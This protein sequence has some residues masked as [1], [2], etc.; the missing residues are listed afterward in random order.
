LVGADPDIFCPKNVKR[1]K[2][3]TFM[4]SN[5]TGI[6][7]NDGYQT[8]REL[9]EA[10]LKRGLDLHIYG[11]NWEYLA[12]EPNLHIH[13]FVD[14]EQ[15]AKA[16]SRSRITIGISGTSNVRKANSWR[17][18]FNSMACGAFHLTLYVPGMEEIFENRKH[19]VW[20]NSVPEAIELIEYYLAHD[21]EREQIAEAGR[22][23]ILAHH[24][25]DVRIAEMIDIYER[26]RAAVL[27]RSQKKSWQAELASSEEELNENSNVQAV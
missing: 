15:F 14:E 21:Q 19:L 22:Q 16:C 8:R 20:F 17:R 3:V 5:V 13:S 27:T 7:R 25:W 4:G 23:E 1:T 9:I 12:H 24:T 18:T 6:P 10:I 2:D 26:N 11:N